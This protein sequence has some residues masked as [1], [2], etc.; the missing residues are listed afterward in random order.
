[1]KLIVF[2]VLLSITSISSFLFS[3]G[4][5]R[6]FEVDII[7]DDINESSS[8]ID[9]FLS[10][11]SIQPKNRSKKNYQFDVSFY[12]TNESFDSFLDLYKQ[13]GF[14]RNEKMISND[15]LKQEKIKLNKKI[16]SLEKESRLYFKLSEYADTVSPEQ[17]LKF[18]EKLILIEKQ[19]AEIEL[20]LLE[21]DKKENLNRIS[22]SVSEEKDP[23][24][25]YNGNWINMPGVEGSSLW[26]EQPNSGETASQMIGI[27]LKY[28]FNSKKTYGFAGLYRSL[29]QNVSTD[30]LYVVGFGQDFYS[31]RL[32]KG[33][34]KFFNLYTSLNTGVYIATGENQ[35]SASWFINP[36]LGVEIFKNKYFLIDNKVGYFLPYRD[37]RHMR[38][39]LYNFSINFAF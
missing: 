10:Q 35:N 26:I 6:T 17:N 33:Q 30:E 12:A 21:I 18:K 34:R 7:T 19:K 36:Y 16:S 1:M 29:D 27:S 20:E 15:L 9:S 23:T 13:L 14:V 38:G 3:Q 37:N 11:Y 5:N 28:L 24:K 22:L 2:I 39:L 4:Q 31:K 8:L 32:G 25:E